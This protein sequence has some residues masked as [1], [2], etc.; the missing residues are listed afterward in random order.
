MQGGKED[1]YDNIK[2]HILQTEIDQYTPK[3]TNLLGKK[4]E[5]RTRLLS[6][7]LFSSAGYHRFFRSVDVT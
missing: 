3:N 6:L 5:K 7:I 2:R 1:Y 4:M